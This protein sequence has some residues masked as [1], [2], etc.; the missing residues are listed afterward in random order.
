MEQHCEIM[1]FFCS[2]TIFTDKLKVLEGVLYRE[3]NTGIG[4]FRNEE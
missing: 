4:L 1:F 3:I 2:W